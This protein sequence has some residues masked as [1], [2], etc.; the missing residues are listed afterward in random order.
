MCYSFKNGGG[1]AFK[2]GCNCTQ[3]LQEMMLED[4]GDNDKEEGAKR[5]RKKW[6]PHLIILFEKLKLILSNRDQP[7]GLMALLSIAIPVRIPMK[8]NAT[9]DYIV[10]LESIKL[11]LCFSAMWELVGWGYQKANE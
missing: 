11:Y 9:H 1:M 8:Q 5:F 6:T 3:V 10:S 2:T 4:L 7:N